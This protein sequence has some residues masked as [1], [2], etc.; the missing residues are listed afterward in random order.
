MIEFTVLGEPVSKARAR[1]T[2]RGT[3]TPKKTRDAEKAIAEAF[4]Q[5]APKDWEPDSQHDFYVEAYFHNG[6]R[7]RRDL[8]NMMKLVMDA[9][10][11]VCWKDDYQVVM[12][13]ASKRQD[14]AIP[15]TDVVIIWYEDDE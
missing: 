3:Y 7:R 10:N 5:A 6:N 9:L 15:C 1:V 12:M 4:K 14:S 8:D 2:A 13:K 11:K